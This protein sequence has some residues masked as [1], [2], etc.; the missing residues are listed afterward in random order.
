MIAP[1]DVRNLQLFLLAHD[2]TKDYYLDF[3]QASTRIFFSIVKSRRIVLWSDKGC[4]KI[5]FVQ[6]IKSE[7]D[8][9][10]I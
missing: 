9:H 8:L 4:G 10:G 5:F 7:N 2:F 1:Q 6:E 3:S